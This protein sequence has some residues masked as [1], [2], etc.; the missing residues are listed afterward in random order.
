MNVY[1][2]NH[3]ATKG[4]DVIQKELS[5]LVIPFLII[6]IPIMRYEIRHDIID[7]KVTLLLALYGFIFACFKGPHYAATHTIAGIGIIFFFIFLRQ[8]QSGEALGGGAIKLMAAIGAL[9]GLS[10]GFLTILIAGLSLF[11]VY[12][13]LRGKVKLFPSSPFIGIAFSISYIALNHKQ[14]L[15]L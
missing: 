14:L 9:F 11:I 7:D 6:M 2:E 15:A 12:H 1:Y 5:F 3:T 13:L 10:I 4:K 8:F